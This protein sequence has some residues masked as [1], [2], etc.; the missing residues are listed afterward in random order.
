[1]SDGE[2][3]SKAY[4]VYANSILL[5]LQEHGATT[6]GRLQYHIVCREER[7]LYQCLAEMQETG[8]I[9]TCGVET[10]EGAYTGQT[11]YQVKPFPYAQE[12]G[13]IEKNLLEANEE[14]LGLHRYG[15]LTYIQYSDVASLLIDARVKLKG[16]LSGQTTEG[17]K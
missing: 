5:F 12:R 14:L 9:E 4:R 7:D 16:Y 15:A 11:L 13:L 3:K 8:Q 1:M 17:S 10:A 2:K 6:P